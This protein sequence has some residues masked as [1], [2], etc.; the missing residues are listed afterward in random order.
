[1][2]SSG[3]ARFNTEA[4]AWD[5]NPTVLLASDLAHRAILRRFPGKETT[6]R[7]DVL[8]IGCG[9]GLL[10]LA[11]APSFR[12]IT[13]VDAAEGMVA[14][15]Q[16]K[17]DGGGC[18]T[19]NVRTVCAMLEDPDDERI[20]PDAAASGSRPE[21]EQ[22][23]EP[24][25]FDLIVS[26]LVLHHIPELQPLMRTMFGCLKPGGQVMLTDFEDFGPEARRFHP[27][28]KMD[29][30]ERHGIKR[31]DMEAVLSQA[32]FADVKVE[33]AFE[34]DKAVETEPGNGVMGPTMSF[35]FL[36]CIGKRP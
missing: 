24:R 16:A 3:N 31:T 20:R 27:E 33:T 25:R 32:R 4:A 11:L 30:V 26:H 29:G 10:S 15:L 21:D 8:E 17:L 35:P 34:M 18:G 9:T 6:S 2:A 28:S 36:L 19:K 5:S 1:M 23:L 12:S 13:A 22:G 7:L 14:A